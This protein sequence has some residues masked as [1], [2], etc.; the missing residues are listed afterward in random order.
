MVSP[1]GTEPCDTEDCRLTRCAYWHNRG[2][3]GW[4]SFTAYVFTVDCDFPRL[5]GYDCNNCLGAKRALDPTDE[6]SP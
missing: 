3:L 5:F 6:L 1:A 2:C 4:A